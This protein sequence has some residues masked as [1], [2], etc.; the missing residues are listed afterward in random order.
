MRKMYAVVYPAAGSPKKIG[1]P[2]AADPGLCVVTN[3]GIVLLM[4][5]VGSSG[6]WVGRIG[7]LVADPG[8]EDD[9]D[10]AGTPAGCRGS[11]SNEKVR[12][13]DARTTEKV[14]GVTGSWVDV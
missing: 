1:P 10:D 9:D 11:V 6:G 7:E 3:P 4:T 13:Q 12:R 8:S 2:D 14:A 5:V